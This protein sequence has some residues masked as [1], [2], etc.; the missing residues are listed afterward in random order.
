MGDA[1]CDNS[2]KTTNGRINLENDLII[3]IAKFGIMKWP[4]SV[5]SAQNE[6]MAYRDISRY[7]IDKEMSTRAKSFAYK[8]M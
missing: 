5:L 3:K 1:N 4:L 6:F 2:L 7:S 8:I